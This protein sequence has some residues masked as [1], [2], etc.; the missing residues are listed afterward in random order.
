MSLIFVA[1]LNKY[2]GRNITASKFNAISTDIMVSNS[3]I[4]FL[5]FYNRC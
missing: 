4:Q 3:T 1:S 5:S 2:L